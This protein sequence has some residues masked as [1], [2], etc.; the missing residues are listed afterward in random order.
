MSGMERANWEITKKT[1]FEVIMPRKTGR[2]RIR[3]MI[4]I[5]RKIERNI[6][7]SA[8]LNSGISNPMKKAEKKR[9]IKESCVTRGKIIV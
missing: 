3:L 1:T 6:A 4:S 8:S 2:D 7:I 5:V 9:T